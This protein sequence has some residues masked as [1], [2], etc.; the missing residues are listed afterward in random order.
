MNEEF[1]YHLLPGTLSIA[2]KKLC[3]FVYVSKLAKH[4]EIVINLSLNLVVHRGVNYEK[5]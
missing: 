5:G 3:N 2:E 1:K 4:P